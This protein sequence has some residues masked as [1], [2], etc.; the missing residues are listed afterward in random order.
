VIDAED[1]Q[2]SFDGHDQLPLLLELTNPNL[3]CSP[4]H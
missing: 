2:N 1:A 3:P 4:I